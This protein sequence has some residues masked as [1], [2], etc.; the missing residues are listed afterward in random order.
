MLRRSLITNSHATFML[1]WMLNTSSIRGPP[2]L[3]ICLPS[4]SLHVISVLSHVCRGKV[5]ALI[6]SPRHTQSCCIKFHHFPGFCWGGRG[7]YFLCFG[8]QARQ[9]CLTLSPVVSSGTAAFHLLSVRVQDSYVN[10]N[11]RTCSINWP[12]R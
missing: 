10:T 9:H 1:G 4:N 11:E 7:G 8:D 5:N 3:L 2:P 12:F 6:V